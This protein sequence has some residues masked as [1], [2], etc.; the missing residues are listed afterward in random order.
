MYEDVWRREESYDA[1]VQ[2]A[3]RAGAGLDG[4]VGLNNALMQMQVSLSDWS[5]KKRCEKENKEGEEGV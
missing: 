2:D 3:W 4:L 1:I 5:S